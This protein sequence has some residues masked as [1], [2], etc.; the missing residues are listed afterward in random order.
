M[1]TSA[2]KV[3]AVLESKLSYCGTCYGKGVTEKDV[4]VIDYVNGGYIET[5]YEPCQECGGDG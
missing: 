5:R 4:P 1:P 2:S 3:K